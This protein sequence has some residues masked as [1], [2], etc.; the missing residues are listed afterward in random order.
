M[1]AMPSCHAHDYSSMRTERCRQTA[2]QTAQVLERAHKPVPLPPLSMIFLGPAHE[3]CPRCT[4]YAGGAALNRACMHTPQGL[5]SQTGGLC[6]RNH[7]SGGNVDCSPHPLETYHTSQRT[8]L[9]QACG[10]E[11]CVWSHTRDIRAQVTCHSCH[12]WPTQPTP[13]APPAVPRGAGNRTLCLLLT[14]EVCVPG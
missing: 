14:A 8:A 11:V 9:P 10:C 12:P 4:T 7:A 2:R 6:T 3:V 1:P 5:G 13:P